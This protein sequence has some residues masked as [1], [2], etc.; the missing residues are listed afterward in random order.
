MKKKITI[1]TAFEGTYVLGA[2]VMI[3]ELVQR[4]GSD[5]GQVQLRV[6]CNVEDAENTRLFRDIMMHLGI[7]CEVV[8]LVTDESKRRR[9]NSPV[10][11]SK[12][13]FLRTEN[14]PLLWLDADTLCTSKFSISDYTEST[15][16]FLVVPRNG[17]CRN[18]NSGVFFANRTPFEI[19]LSKARDSDF[20][21]DQHILQDNIGPLAADLAPEH[22]HLS[23]WAGDH[24]TLDPVRIYHYVGEIKPWFIS[25]AGRDVCTGANCDYAAWFRAEKTLIS[26]L[27]A[28]QELLERYEAAQGVA[29]KSPRKVIGPA[30]RLAMRLQARDSKS[31]IRLFSS[32]MYIL[33][34]IRPKTLGRHFPNMHPFH[35]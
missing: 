4:L 15:K 22:N 28:D 18:F 29:V 19:E 16:D 30:S 32:L 1:A 6:A 26:Q 12:F 5:I 24:Q 25:R 21:T 33:S 3:Y 7:A 17:D 20:Y 35:V 10:A 8:E 14:V 11:L 23:I 31:L 27:Q 34:L 2:T 13:H 9:Y